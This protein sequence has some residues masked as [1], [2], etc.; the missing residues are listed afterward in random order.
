MVLLPLFL[1]NGAG[2]EYIT[3]EILYTAAVLTNKVWRHQS[4]DVRTHEPPH[5]LKDACAINTVY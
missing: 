5:R 3:V 2:W 4:V 1:T